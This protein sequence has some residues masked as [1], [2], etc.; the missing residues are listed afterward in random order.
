MEVCS[1]GWWG[2][3]AEEIGGKLRKGVFDVLRNG[4]DF[5]ADGH[6]IMVVLPAWHEMEMQMVG[7][8][9][10]SR[11]TEIK[12]DIDAVG[13][14]MA[15]KHCAAG[16]EHRHDPVVLLSSEFG[17]IG[18][19]PAWGHEQMTIGIRKAIEQHHSLVIAIQ[20]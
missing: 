6:E 16:G 11:R 18:Q 17:E 14:E 7:N 4:P 5:C 1:W 3:Q 10:A 12:A 8:A 9:G 2:A 20:Q 15:A 19:M 13:L